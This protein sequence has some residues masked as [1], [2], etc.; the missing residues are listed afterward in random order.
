MVTTCPDCGAEY[1]GG[2][3]RFCGS[4]GSLL[5]G[6]EDAQIGTSAPDRWGLRTQ[7]APEGEPEAQDASALRT[8]DGGPG[9]TT[10]GQPGRLGL[11]VAGGVV[12]LALGSV[13]LTLQDSAE[14]TD[15]GPGEPQDVAQEQPE[16]GASSSDDVQGPVSVDP[17]HADEV[18]EY[19]TALRPLIEEDLT[20]LAELTTVLDGTY[21]SRQDQLDAF[22]EASEAMGTGTQLAVRAAAIDPPPGYELAQGSFVAW[23]QQRGTYGEAVEAAATRDDVL[24]LA[25]AV[26]RYNLD[27]ARFLLAAP[28][29]MC[30]ELSEFAAHITP[31]Y[32]RYCR[33]PATLPNDDYASEIWSVTRRL[34]MEV[35]P[36]TSPQ[37]SRLA[38][39]QERLAYLQFTLPDMREA[40]AD[41]RIRVGAL[42]PPPQLNNDHRA[43]LTFLDELGDHY[44]VRL[45]AAM[46]GDL[47]EE[48]SREGDQ[49]A[50]RFAAQLSPDGRELFILL[51]LD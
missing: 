12:V 25:I 44:D 13:V 37:V 27:V 30:R 50:R 11:T 41:A 10:A 29:P 18:D 19:L 28:P 9:E 39:D 7:A 8:G 4:C 15:P 43:L 16:A 46:A 5:D 14:V 20:A 38:R 24:N 36:R 17:G 22:A 51:L 3:A 6:P 2:G 45:A 31:R 35:F 32:E 42:E 34:T 26:K 47:A 48:R 1:Q 49:I 21:T 40:V 23:L 33:D